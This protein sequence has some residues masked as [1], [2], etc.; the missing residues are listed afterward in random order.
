MKGNRVMRSRY[1]A[2]ISSLLIGVGLV[3][4]AFA[5][6]GDGGMLQ[7]LIN[8][9]PAI[10]GLVIVIY[11]LIRDHLP[12]QQKVFSD[13]LANQQRSFGEAIAAN[14]Q[15]VETF[16][17]FMRDT[18]AAESAAMVAVFEKLL[19]HSERT[20]EEIAKEIKGLGF[21]FGRLRSVI[22]QHHDLVRARAEEA[23]AA[24]IDEEREEFA[25]GRARS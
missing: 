19:A 14:A 24:A 16:I 22:H 11:Y 6:T 13:T 18:R 5:Q 12:A 9:S 21:G 20:S 2:V 7:S 1:V 25:S 10:A 8:S 3:A 23:A 4:P 17:A 15:Q